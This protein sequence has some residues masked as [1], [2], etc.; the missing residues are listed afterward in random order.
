MSSNEVTHLKAWELLE[1]GAKLGTLPSFAYV[2]GTHVLYELWSRGAREGYVALPNLYGRVLRS[3]ETGRYIAG[4][5]DVLVHE[6]IGTR[7]GSSEYIVSPHYIDALQKLHIS[8]VLRND[9]RPR[10]EQQPADDGTHFTMSP[11][12]REGPNW[13]ESSPVYYSMPAGDTRS[14]VEMFADSFDRCM[15]THDIVMGFN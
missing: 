7:I 10:P 2:L 13:N 11:R 1:S 6:G 8:G 3:Q 4:Q 12:L 9:L 5:I 14:V 15:P